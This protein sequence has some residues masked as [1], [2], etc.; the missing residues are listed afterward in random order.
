[1]KAVKVKVSGRVQGVYFRA[2]TQ[3]QAKSLGIKGTV[4]NLDDGSVYI[5][6]EGNKENLDLFISW[7]KSGP[8]AARVDDF[9]CEETEVK[10]FDSFS[11]IR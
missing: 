4:K 10:H 5:E 7:C 11:I 8:P 9:T 6:A 3:K 1:M 2:S